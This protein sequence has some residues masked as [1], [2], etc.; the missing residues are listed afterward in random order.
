M[1]YQYAKGVLYSPEGMIHSY[2]GSFIKV[3]AIPEPGAAASNSG[4]KVDLISFGELSRPS[5]PS[6]PAGDT[7]ASTTITSSFF[8]PYGSSIEAP[9][10]CIKA[11]GTGSLLIHTGRTVILQNQFRRVLPN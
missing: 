4:S 7:V 9:M 2:T 1:S 8:L 11:T 5:N 3:T 6:D 10:F